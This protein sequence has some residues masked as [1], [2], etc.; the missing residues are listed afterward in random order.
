MTIEV[1]SLR[2]LLLED[3]AADANL[4]RATLGAVSDVA[5]D[6]EWVDQL[7]PALDRLAKGGIDVALINLSLPDSDGMD[8]FR[9][10]REEAPDI[11]V[12]ILT[13]Y[14]GQHLA[15]TA[16]SEGAHDYLLKNELWPGTLARALR[17]AVGRQQQVADLR[18]LAL[19]DDLT[20]LHNRR[21]FLGLGDQLIKVADRNAMGVS[22]VYCDVN[23]LKAI[24]DKHGHHR[25]DEALMG[26][27]EALRRSFRT[28]DVVAR[29]GGDEFCA[30]LVAD[31]SGGD[32]PLAR[33]LAQEALIGGGGTG[34][35]SL[36][37]GVAYRGP[38]SDV[39]VEEL[40]KRADAAMYANKFSGEGRPTTTREGSS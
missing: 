5:F 3:N 21:G 11:P 22:L 30:L 16:T 14:E 35:V 32:I 36:A 29:V 18:H 38:G 37:I 8:T 17:Q 2:V 26:V 27:A 1:A 40:M 23:S 13:S 34:P 31:G 15:V 33:L 28:S 7:R 4:L 12:L 20:G 10:V 19:V 25:G 24:N 39:S 6:V 9:A